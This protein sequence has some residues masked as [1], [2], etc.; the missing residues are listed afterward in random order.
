MTFAEEK[1]ETMR[2]YIDR[3]EKMKERD[4]LRKP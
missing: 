1:A 4:K 2:F 3:I